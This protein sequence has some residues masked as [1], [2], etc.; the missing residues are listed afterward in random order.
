MDFIDL[1]LNNKKKKTNW[2]IYGTFVLYRHR[3][4]TSSKESSTELLIQTNVPRTCNTRY[5]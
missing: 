3:P 4:V 1:H 2:D 5:Q